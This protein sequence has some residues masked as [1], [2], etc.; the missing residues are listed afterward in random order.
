MAI[1][2]SL[3]IAPQHP[4]LYLATDPNKKVGPH[5]HSSIETISR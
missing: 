5:T 4:L 3:F 1:K 2:K